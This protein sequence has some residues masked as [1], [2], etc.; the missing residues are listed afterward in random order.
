VQ[1]CVPDTV[2]KDVHQ[3]IESKKNLW[4]TSILQMFKDENNKFDVTR[5][6]SPRNMFISDMLEIPSITKRHGYFLNFEN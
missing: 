2:T 3:K 1:E 6:T 5:R 4:F